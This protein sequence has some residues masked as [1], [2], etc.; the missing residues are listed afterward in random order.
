MCYYL[1]FSDEGDKISGEDQ[2]KLKSLKMKGL[3]HYNRNRLVPAAACYEKA[4]NMAIALNDGV[5]GGHDFTSIL[6]S[7]NKCRHKMG[8][9]DYGEEEEEEDDEW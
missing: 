8:K 9:G 2:S 6:Q 1:L 5:P 7:L 4:L 3:L